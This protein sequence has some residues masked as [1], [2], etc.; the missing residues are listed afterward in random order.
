MDDTLKHRIIGGIILAASAAIFLPLFFK[1]N[2]H[3][4]TVEKS[5]E[6]E[7]PSTP[8]QPDMAFEDSPKAVETMEPIDELAESA[9]AQPNGAVAAA[10][11]ELANAA[12]IQPPPLQ[13]PTAAT[14]SNPVR[15]PQL[16]DAADPAAEP[17]QLA[18]NDDVPPVAQNKVLTE[19]PGLEEVVAVAPKAKSPVV[20]KP[21]L[22]AKPISKSKPVVAKAKVIAEK[23]KVASLQPAR[24]HEFV[25]ATT[26]T[27]AVVAPPAGIALP[28]VAANSNWVVQCASFS[29]SD[30]AAALQNKLAA[31]GFQSYVKDAQTPSGTITRVFVGPQGS[32]AAAVAVQNQLLAKLQTK[33][34]VVSAG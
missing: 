9:N 21:T 6:F 2:H 34:I 24:P 33:G 18:E 20:N 3:E 17:Q 25:P 19:D 30:H 32:R 14:Q 1:G 11:A 29:S 7:I 12:D 16:A 27:T 22:A 15:Q 26:Q 10:N 8:A 4:T 23:T 13:G 28:S 31:A 5:H